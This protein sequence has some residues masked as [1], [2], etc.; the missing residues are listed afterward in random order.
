MKTFAKINGVGE[1]KANRYGKDFLAE[2]Q[3]FR[4]SFE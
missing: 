4:G 1:A 2:I 3:R